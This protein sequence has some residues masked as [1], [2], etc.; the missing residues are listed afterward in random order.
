MMDE[1]K[2]CHN[3]ESHNYTHVFVGKNVVLYCTKCAN[4]LVLTKHENPDP[5]N[6]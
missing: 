1:T 4:T 2:I 5:K 3:N 6:G